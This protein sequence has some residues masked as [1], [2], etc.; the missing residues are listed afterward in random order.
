MI[1]KRP[2]VLLILI[3]FSVIYFFIPDKEKP[4][5]LQQSFTPSPLINSQLPEFSLTDIHGQLRHNKEWANKIL[6]IN[7]W[8]TWCPP[9]RKEIP[10]FIELQNKY[11]TQGV[12]FIGIA[13][14]ETDKVVELSQEIGINYPV[15]VGN[16]DA[17]EI[18]EKLGDHQ[19]VLPYTVIVDTRGR[20]KLVHSGEIA[21]QT[22][23][24][25]L[26]PLLQE[27]H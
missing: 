6:V 12:Q 18:A 15:L 10:L 8:A 20:I 17:I 25:A 22:L 13:I 26:L 5:N 3:L 21:R 1:K 27:K 7:F 4:N 14:D 9:C 16:H 24:E 11:R 23:Q 19:G 2:V